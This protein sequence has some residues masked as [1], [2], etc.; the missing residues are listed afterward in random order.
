MGTSPGGQDVVEVRGLSKA[1]LG[2]AAEF[3]ARYLPILRRGEP[4]GC[5]ILFDP[6]DHTH[7]SWRLAMVQELARAAAPRRVNAIVGDDA[8]A[9][10]KT[11]AYLDSAPG[12]TGQLFVLGAP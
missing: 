8:D 1:P 9:F 5:I 7:R 4:G 12:V 2:A 11:I 6:A 3:A 10:R